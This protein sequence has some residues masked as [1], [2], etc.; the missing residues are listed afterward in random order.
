[1]CLKLIHTCR[2]F[3][4]KIRFRV[5]TY[6]FEARFATA[7]RQALGIGSGVPPRMWSPLPKKGGSISTPLKVSLNGSTLSG[8][9][10]S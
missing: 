8:E 3:L 2:E 5:L 10:L 6:G 1:M 4:M 9:T 7:A